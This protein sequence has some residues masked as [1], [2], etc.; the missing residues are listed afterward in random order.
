MLAEVLR[1]IRVYHDLNQ[2]EAAEKLKI[3]KSYLSEIESGVKTPTLPL[4]EAYAAEFKI[5]PSAILFFAESRD[6]DKT[7]DKAK[8]FVSNKILRLL[9]YIE[10]RSEAK[11]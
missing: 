9:Q 6:G 7:S 10:E 4:I 11:K 8:Q 3:S 1:L 2:K 5:P